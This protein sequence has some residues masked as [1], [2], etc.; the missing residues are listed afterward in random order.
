MLFS[1]K[2]LTQKRELTIR[3]FMDPIGEY[4]QLG[5]DPEFPPPATPPSPAGHSDIHPHTIQLAQERTA[6]VTL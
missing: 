1:V 5:V 3:V 2:N 6:G 4:C